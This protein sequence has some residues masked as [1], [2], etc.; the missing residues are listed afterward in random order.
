MPSHEARIFQDP[1]YGVSSIREGIE[2]LAIVSGGSNEPQAGRGIAVRPRAGDSASADT[3]S[4]TLWPHVTRRRGTKPTA[5]ELGA[6]AS[7]SQDNPIAA[8]SQGTKTSSS[9]MEDP[10]GTPLEIPRPSRPLKASSMSGYVTSSWTS[11]IYRGIRGVPGLSPEDK[12]FAHILGSQLPH[13]LA[14]PQYRFA[15]ILR[16]FVNNDDKLEAMQKT[17]RLMGAQ[18]LYETFEILSEE[19]S[20]RRDPAFK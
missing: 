11:K 12:R 8:S 20:R 10:R 15:D 3:V 16:S 4:I 13:Y 18:V 6:Q 1:L 2:S 7:G 5:G 9:N 14:S 19:S 17:V